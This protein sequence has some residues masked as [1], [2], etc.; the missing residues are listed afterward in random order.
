MNGRARLESNP[1]AN[2]SM[3]NRPTA[4]RSNAIVR[5]PVGERERSSLTAHGR[6]CHGHRR[7]AAEPVRYKALAIQHFQA[8]I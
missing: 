3:S 7:A 8:D 5:T 2:I 1:V 4:R 6:S